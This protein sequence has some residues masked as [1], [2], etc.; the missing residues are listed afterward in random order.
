MNYFRPIPG[1]ATRIDLFDRR[2]PP[3]SREHFVPTLP[4]PIIPVIVRAAY[5]SRF[6]PPRSFSAS[7]LPDSR[8]QMRETNTPGLRPRRRTSYSG[9]W[10][11]LFSE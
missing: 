3:R 8:I 1:P 4:S 7:F 9:D 5:F 10:S 2:H 11:I 6:R